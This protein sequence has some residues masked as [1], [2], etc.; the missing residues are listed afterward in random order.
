[1]QKR[2]IEMHRRSIIPLETREI[3][4]RENK[5]EHPRWRGYNR[6]FAEGEGAAGTFCNCQ[7]ANLSDERLVARGLATSH[8][9]RHNHFIH[10]SLAFSARGEGWPVP[11][12]ARVMAAIC[13][14]L[15][16]SG[17]ACARITANLRT[18]VLSTHAPLP[19]ILRGWRPSIHSRKYRAGGGGGQAF[20]WNSTDSRFWRRGDVQRLLLIAL[21]SKR[22][23][24]EEKASSKCLTS[25]QIRYVGIELNEWN[26]INFKSEI[27]DLGKKKKEKGQSLNK[28]R[29]SMLEM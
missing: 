29:I 10:N 14:L 25:I 5:G 22:V 20:V 15:P 18:C 17:P 26:R 23:A 13:T 11:G 2:T 6:R 9:T 27:Y 28:F 19:S 3:F 8:H 12:A 4:L 16:H 21:E 24:I 1:M 7:R